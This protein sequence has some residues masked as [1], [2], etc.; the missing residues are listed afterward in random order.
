MT[1]LLRA[2]RKT[3]EGMT[4]AEYCIGIVSACALAMVLY[5][6]VTGGFVDHLIK[7]VITKAFGLI[8]L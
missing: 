8:G 1:R 5:K 3:D 6:I 2:L 7:G 4:T